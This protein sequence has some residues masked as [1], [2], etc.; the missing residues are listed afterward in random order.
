MKLVQMPA[1]LLHVDES[2]L[3]AGGYDAGLLAALYDYLPGALSDRRGAAILAP[4]GGGGRQVLML[5]ARRIGAA[6]RDE[7]IAARDSGGDMTAQKKRLCYLPGQ[8][9]GGALGLP[10]ARAALANE[11]ACFL[12]DLEAATAAPG[13]PHPLPEPAVPVAEVLALLD[14][15]LRGGLPTFLNAD[16]AR[17]PADLVA[18]LRA[19]LLVLEPASS[20]RM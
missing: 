3:E 5:L 9:L 6:L 17:L 7:N 16:P 20:A 8:M 14:A 12:Q 15:R 10:D 1:N 13:H 2:D 18:A 19:R 4:A 11:A